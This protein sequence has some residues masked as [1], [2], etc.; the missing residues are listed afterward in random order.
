MLEV[1]Q[2]QVLLQQKEM[3]VIIQFFQQLQLQVVVL[4][5]WE[6]YL[7]HQ[8]NQKQ[9]EIQEDQAEVAVLF[10]V[11]LLNQVKEQ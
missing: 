1:V 3:M 10:L 6:I 7:L 9:M 2:I 11:V 8:D 4:V 5:D